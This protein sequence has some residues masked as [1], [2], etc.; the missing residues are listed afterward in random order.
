MTI[1]DKTLLNAAK[2]DEQTA[3]N[4]YQEAVNAADV[5]EDDKAAKR[6]AAFQK[7]KYRENLVK[8]CLDNVYTTNELNETTR[9]ASAT[10]SEVGSLTENQTARSAK[11]FDDLISAR[12]NKQ[13]MI[14]INTYYSKQYNAY[15]EI[16][17]TIFDIS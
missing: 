6:S 14:E 8:A 1:C 15:T 4:A 7:M 10:T 13:R 11:A 5:D 12:N 9:E 16:F 17:K 2:Q 3:L